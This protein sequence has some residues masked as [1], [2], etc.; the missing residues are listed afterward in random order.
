MP[1]SKSSLVEKTSPG[2]GYAKRNG[3][4]ACLGLDAFAAQEARLVGP[5]FR[6][7][8]Q[9]WPLSAGGKRADGTLC[10]TSG[11]VRRLVLDAFAH[12]GSI[13]HALRPAEDFDDRYYYL[14]TAAELKVVFDGRG[15][16]LDDPWHEVFDCEDFAYSL[17][18]DFALN[19]LINARQ[20]MSTPFA[21][22]I[23]WGGVRPVS[24]HVLNVAVT[25]DAGVLLLDGDLDAGGIIAAE[26]RT[27]P[28][29]YIV[30]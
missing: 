13:D 3:R 18:T 15:A 7:W 24:R 21:V 5:H 25:A 4:P 9:S 19:R 28:I 14:P 29:D 11:E 2:L 23:L 1:H 8:W 17:R 6:R 10:V 22:G 20:G 27:E 26:K 30:I 12:L 16:L